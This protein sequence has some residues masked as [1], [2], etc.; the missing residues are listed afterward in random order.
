MSIGRV[1]N[2][3][4]ASILETFVTFLME[5]VTSWKVLALWMLNLRALFMVRG[6]K[7]TCNL[8]LGF[9]TKTK[10]WHQSVALFISS[11]LITPSVII[12]LISCLSGSTIACGIFLGGWMSGM[13]LWSR[14]NFMIASLMVPTPSKSSGNN[15]ITW[16][17][18]S[19]LNLVCTLNGGKHTWFV[20]FCFGMSRPAGNSLRMST[21]TFLQ[22]QS[23]SQMIFTKSNALQNVKP[24]KILLSVKL[25][26]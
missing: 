25:V 3:L 11:F 6:S 16:A 19:G 9:Q 20:C 22:A 17:L 21:I 4:L 26:M 8:P 13:M 7:H 24:S 12:L 1:Q 10:L 18:Q 14:F 15:S 2:P 23:L 5:D